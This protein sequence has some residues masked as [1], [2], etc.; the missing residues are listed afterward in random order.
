MCVFF[1]LFIYS[2]ARENL[3]FVH[4]QFS[5]VHGRHDQDVQHGAQNDD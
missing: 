1:F 4:G 5:V 3:H 2:C